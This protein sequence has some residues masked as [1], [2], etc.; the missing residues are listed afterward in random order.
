MCASQIPCSFSH[1]ELS[2]P[3][4]CVPWCII[5]LN[6]VLKTSVYFQIPY[7]SIKVLLSLTTKSL[8]ALQFVRQ[9]G[10]EWSHE[11]TSA[12]HMEPH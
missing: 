11:L 9:A 7:H 1:T 4:S 12:E 5:S 3:K 10:R 2:L 8:K 6:K